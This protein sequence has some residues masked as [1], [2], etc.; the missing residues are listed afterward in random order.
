MPAKNSAVRCNP[1][2]GKAAVRQKGQYSSAFIIRDSSVPGHHSSVSL[3]RDFQLYTLKTTQLSRTGPSTDRAYFAL[4]IGNRYSEMP[5]AS[6]IGIPVVSPP[7]SPLQRL[8]LPGLDRAGRSMTSRAHRSAH[9]HGLTIN[10]SRSHP[11]SSPAPD[12]TRNECG[13]VSFG[14]LS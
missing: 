6:G 10:R 14:R 4:S 9:K 13:V 7:C 2:E 5:F 1:S 3:G 11:H 12:A 8:R